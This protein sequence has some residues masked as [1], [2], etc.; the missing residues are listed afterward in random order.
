MIRDEEE[1]YLS[2]LEQGLIP[3]MASH[4]LGE[5]QWEFIEYFSKSFGGEMLP[6]MYQEIDEYVTKQRGINLVG[7]KKMS[8]YVSDSYLWNV[9]GEKD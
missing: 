1:T 9:E 5:D 4:W 2:R 3:R 7:Y 6:P 8:Y